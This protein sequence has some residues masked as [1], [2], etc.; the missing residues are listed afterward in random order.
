MDDTYSRGSVVELSDNF[1][2]RIVI[3]LYKG[4]LMQVNNYA[5]KKRGIFKSKNIL[6]ISILN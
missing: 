2:L 6:L 3:S 5:E 1:F 4:L